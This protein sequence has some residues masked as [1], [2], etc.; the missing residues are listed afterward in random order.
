M[1]VQLWKLIFSDNEQMK[2]MSWCAIVIWITMPEVEWSTPNNMLDNTMGL[3]SLASVFFF[4]K[5]FQVR[6][7]FNFTIASM[8]LLA[9][10]LSK[11]PIGLFPLIL[12]L[13]Y[14]LIFGKQYV[15]AMVKCY[16]IIITSIIIFCLYVYVDKSAY[17][18]LTTYI[19]QQIV[20]GLL[21]NREL[22]SNGSKIDYLIIIAN[23][24]QNAFNILLILTIIWII[25]NKL[26]LKHLSNSLKTKWI[27]LMLL[28][29]VSGSFPILLSSKQA[30][31]YLIPCLPMYAIGLAIILAH[32]LI[33]IFKEVTISNNQE[34]II[35]L[36]LIIALLLI[37]IYALSFISKKRNETSD[38]ISDIYKIRPYLQG[39]QKVEVCKKLMADFNVHA[40]FNR[41]LR[42][43][44][45]LDSVNTKFSI[46]DSN[47]NIDYQKQLDRNRFKEIVL[48]TKRIKIYK[49]QPI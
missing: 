46:L 19:K 27:L 23:Q 26:R 31:Y 6:S 7:V 34:K 45:S 48:P 9:A 11:G 47:C 39:Y 4:I 15:N 24:L 3:F 5:G 36:V 29:G 44:L 41:Y 32:L 18:L 13:F 12:P 20:S 2:K 49:K 21:G 38:L 16:F 42:V 30:G 37:N 28:L 14:L 43:E 1:I 10:F 40:N 8:L 17:Q 22:T 33:D 25:R 35:K